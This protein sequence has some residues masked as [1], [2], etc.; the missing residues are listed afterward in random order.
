MSALQLIPRIFLST[1]SARRATHSKRL[2]ARRDYISIHALREE[3]DPLARCLDYHGPHFYP[4][5]PR[6]GRHP[7]GR[8]LIL[9]ARDFYPRPPRG[10]RRTRTCM[11]CRISKF[12]STPSA[13]RATEK[14]ERTVQN[15]EIS[16][17]ALREEGDPTMRLTIPLHLQ[18]SIHAL[19]E[20]GD[21]SNAA[22]SGDF[23]I[24]I[25]ALR[26]EGDPNAPAMFF[27]AFAFLSTPSAR[28]ATP[29]DLALSMSAV[30]FYPR[31]PRGGRPSPVACPVPP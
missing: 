13:R 22:A 4:R 18:I 1:P 9:N 25:H 11:R 20:E 5:P 3:G 6:G 19:R 16:I 23:H 27:P 24:S 21:H 8:K 29:S 14:N 28:R 12:L 15:W 31:P 26:E 30:H 17:H 10:G 2:E 7:I